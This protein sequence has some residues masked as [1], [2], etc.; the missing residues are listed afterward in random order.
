MSF[1]KEKENFSS[2]L[3]NVETANKGIFAIVTFMAASIALAISISI[4]IM[5]NQISV[6]QAS[7]IPTTSYS[8]D[9]DERLILPNMISS[10]K[11]EVMSTVNS[12]LN[13]VAKSIEEV[14]TVMERKKEEA[15]IEAERKAAEEAARI[16]AEE[17]AA[18]KAAEEQARKDELARTI[19]AND[20]DSISKARQF[21]RDGVWNDGTWRYTY[22]SSRVLHHYKTSEWNLGE[23]LIYRDDNG[24]VI[25]AC[26]K[27]PNGTIIEDTMFGTAI[28]QDCGVGRNDTLDVYCAF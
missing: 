16:A 1:K 10:K 26:D 21:K 6:A 13:D 9:V 4:P 24:Y 27:Y 22:Y 11:L 15:R 18:R 23:D 19:A 20:A 7:E 28:V 2:I 3:G 25:V 8:N 5:S 12:S 17:E 14:N